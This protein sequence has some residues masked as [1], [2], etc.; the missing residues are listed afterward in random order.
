[1]A[2]S[3]VIA[4]P[5]AAKQK[6][7]QPAR[8]DAQTY[9]EVMTALPQFPERRVFEASPYQRRCEQD[10]RLMLESGEAAIMQMAL[11][12]FSVMDENDRLR[13]H[14]RLLALSLLNRAGAEHALAWLKYENAS[15]ERKQDI[16]RAALSI[17]HE[18]GL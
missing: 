5:T 3:N 13:I 9:M 11:A 6:V 1:M 12:V 8:R 7:K 10:A 18:F 4:L 17:K 14:G 2:T 16:D 15:K